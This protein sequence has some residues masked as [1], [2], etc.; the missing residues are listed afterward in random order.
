[1]TAP[2]DAIAHS[3]LDDDTRE[4]LLTVYDDL[5]RDYGMDE[6][7][8]MKVVDRLL[9]LADAGEESKATLYQK[10]APTASRGKEQNVESQDD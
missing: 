8:G 3:Q 4:L 1:M 9:A 6:D 10:A 5:Q 7:T 2:R